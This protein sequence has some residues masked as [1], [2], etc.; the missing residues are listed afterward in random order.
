VAA[1]QR[2]PSEGAAPTG[3]S[4]AADVL[5][6]VSSIVRSRLGTAIACVGLLAVLLTAAGAPAALRAPVV[7]VAAL[8]L[9]G[10]PLVARLQVD[11][12]TLLAIDVC[13]S[14]ALEA[15]LA[16]VTVELRFWHPMA[17]GLALAAFGVGGTFS[18]L[19]SLRHAEARH[20]R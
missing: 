20:L 14:L 2:D 7:L 17:L 13:T 18:A 10:Y 3:P 5:P 11:L 12:P 4:D 1:L 8:L 9:P 15:G 19:M 16:V 6:P